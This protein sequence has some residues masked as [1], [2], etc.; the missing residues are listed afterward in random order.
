MTIL[1]KLTKTCLGLKFGTLYFNKTHLKYIEK[2][3]IDNYYSWGFKL[4]PTFADFCSH[5]TL[6]LFSNIDT[7]RQAQ[8]HI[9]MSSVSGSKGP[10]FK[11]WWGLTI[12]QIRNNAGYQKKASM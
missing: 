9:A 2:H 12:Y 3:E 6:K 1:S 4:P 8:L 10:Q 7:N 5:T 11:P